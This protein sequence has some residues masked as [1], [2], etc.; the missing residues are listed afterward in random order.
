[1]GKGKKVLTV[2]MNGD[3]DYEAERTIPPK[4][5]AALLN[6]LNLV[7]VRKIKIKN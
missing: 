4:E 6:W 7:S 1:M 3:G 5:Y 2:Y